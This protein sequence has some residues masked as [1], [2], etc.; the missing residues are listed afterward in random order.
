MKYWRPLCIAALNAKRVEGEKKKTEKI[1]SYIFL[2]STGKKVNDF[3]G[4][5]ADVAWTRHQV[6]FSLP[7]KKFTMTRIRKAA[8]TKFEEVMRN[9][10]TEGLRKMFNRGIG[11]Q[12]V[13]IVL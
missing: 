4:K 2:S 8:Q 3:L 12:Y 13:F 6:R 5:I 9:K 11:H 7:E 10:D 1:L